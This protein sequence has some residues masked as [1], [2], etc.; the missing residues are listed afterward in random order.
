MSDELL[1]IG[2]G[3]AGLTAGMYA[4]RARIRVRALEGGVPGGQVNST[5][6]VE[7][8]PGIK[9]IAG[10]E[11]AQKL[12]DH[13][14]QF[15]LEL[16]YAR[17]ARIAKTDSGFTA[18]TESGKE[19]SSKAVIIAMGAMPVKLGIPGEEKLTGKGVSYC[20]VCDGPFNDGKEV[21]VIGGGDSA[22][23]EAVYLTRHASK[24]HVIHRRDELRAAKEIQEKAFAEP[25]IT[26]H[27]SQ[28]PVEVL[29]EQG[30]EAVRIRSVKDGKEKDLP[31]FSVFFYVGLKPIP[32]EGLQNLVEMDLQGFLIT[33]NYMR[34]C[35]PGLFA[36]G[37]MRSKTLRQITTAVGDGAQ[38]AY[39]AQHYL[40]S[41]E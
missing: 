28:I 12:T 40:E 13:A 21:A 27:W 8:Y 7:N 3:P 11:L 20:A 26:F 31:V 32:L 2:A 30:V 35:T 36:A 37:D 17:V 34:C 10:P 5:A 29:G 1:I 18:I 39:S 38:A 9:N 6:L 22:V 15:G 24:V 19:Y 41:L 16:S 23:E 33:D 4:A 25:K 14:T